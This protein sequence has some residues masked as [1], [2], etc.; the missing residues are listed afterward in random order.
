MRWG[1]NHS[2]L[3]AAFM[4]GF[5]CAIWVFPVLGGPTVQK[6]RLE[7]DEARTKVEALQSEVLTLKE[8]LR[9]QQVEPVIK[10]VRV[11]MDHKDRRVRVEAQRRLQKQL[12]DE[13]VGRAIGDVSSLLL[14]QK[15][16]GVVLDI[17]GVRYQLDVDLIGIGPG[18]ELLLIGSLTPLDV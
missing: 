13:Y 17:D 4:L 3:A 6:L 16:Q 8:A 15:I 9:S 2:R 11:Q 5:A 1:A 14:W 12:W 18:S 7:R 10:A